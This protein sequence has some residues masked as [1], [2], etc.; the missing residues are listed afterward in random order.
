MARALGPKV[1]PAAAGVETQI[2]TALTGIGGSF[3]PSRYKLRTGAE[4]AR[5]ERVFAALI[6]GDKGVGKT[7]VAVSLL[8]LGF[9][10]LLLTTDFGG[11]GYE[12]VF[13]YFEE[14]PEER[15]VLNNLRVVSELDFAGID[16]FSKD[17]T[18]LVPD[19]YEWDPDFIFWDGFSAFQ[20]MEAQSEAAGTESDFK[21]MDWA[22]WNKTRAATLYP[23]NRILEMNNKVTGRVWKKVVT[24]LDKETAEYSEARNKNGE[25]V[26]FKKPGTETTGLMLKTTA[27][28]VVGAGFSTV[29]HLTKQ[30]DLDGKVSHV[31]GVDVLG[32]ESKQRGYQV[33]ATVKGGTFKDLWEKYF[34]PKSMPFEV[35]AAAAGASQGSGPAD[36][37]DEKA[38]TSG[39]TAAS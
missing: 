2:R 14:H 31:W 19:I 20:E 25:V 17:P 4:L 18:V 27:A 8:Q 38:V 39:E 28:A 24:A 34:G 12:T 11:A 15:G 7:Y 23:L 37:K 16:A 30:R 10:V 3:D 26:R 1:E 29:L 36:E 13:S 32:V 9:K 5:A 35:P 6:Y 21:D 22:A 33:P